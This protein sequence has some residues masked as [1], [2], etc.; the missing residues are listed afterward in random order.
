MPYDVG[1]YQTQIIDWLNLFREYG[2][3]FELVQLWVVKPF[4]FRRKN[5]YKKQENLIKNAYKGEIRFYKILPGWRN[6]LFRYIN[7]ALFRYRTKRTFKS[8]DQLVI[9]SRSNIGYSIESLKNKY[10]NR[11]FFY[12]DL[13][14]AGSE[15]I[16]H[17]MKLEHRFSEK[18][19]K[20]LFANTRAYYVC[21]KVADKIFA[22]SETLMDYYHKMFD[23]DVEK[24]VLYPC[25]STTKKFYYDEGIRTKT[26]ERLGYTEKDTVLVYSG[27]TDSTY[28]ISNAFLAL[29]NT[30]SEQNCNIRLLIITKRKTSELLDAI[31]SFSSIKDNVQIIESVP[32]DEMVQYLNAADYGLL[33]RDNIVL[34]NVASPVKFAEYQLCGLPV[35]ISEAVCDYAQYTQKHQT[36]YVLPNAKLENLDFSELNLL[37]K[38]TFNRK[39]I[40]SLAIEN[41]SKESA[42]HRIVKQMNP[43][44]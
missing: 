2:L 11:I 28:C 25:L 18:D 36:G 4:D 34:N 38:N 27:G 15:E 40:S 13:R 16:L 32:N 33:L 10:G 21:Q 1:V 31:D 24:F 7:N 14:A 30:M 19:F 39:H 26:R 3:D 9:F 5:Y 23:T 44:C 37:E 42:I 29:S 6:G 12:W 41:L 22:V 35:I 20:I 17:K 8:N 43:I